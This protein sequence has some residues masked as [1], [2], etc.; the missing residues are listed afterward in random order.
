MSRPR[1]AQRHGSPGR[2]SA[3]AV[4]DSAGRRS[5]S[6]IR[7]LAGRRI[8]QLSGRAPVVVLQPAGGAPV[9]GS[10]RQPQKGAQETRGDRLHMIAAREAAHIGRAAAPAGRVQR[11]DQRD[12]EIRAQQA[13][14]PSAVAATEGRRVQNP[15]EA[16]AMDASECATARTT[17]G[18]RRRQSSD[19]CTVACK[20][21]AER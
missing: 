1:N 4:R 16:S 6:G 3:R 13:S 5:E 2:G 21:R 12:R 14:A 11:E 8:R 10:T 18:H 19:C 17:L 9:G 7:Q 15:L 20:N